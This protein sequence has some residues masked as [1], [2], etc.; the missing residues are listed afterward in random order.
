[1]KKKGIKVLTKDNNN[2]I[3]IIMKG[4]KVNELQRV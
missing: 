3:I 2:D 4:G 1:M